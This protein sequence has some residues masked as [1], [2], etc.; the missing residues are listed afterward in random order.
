MP[1]RA[2]RD[3]A[4]ELVERSQASFFSQARERV[5][6]QSLAVPG[7]GAFVFAPVTRGQRRA[8]FFAQSFKFTQQPDRG[9]VP[10]LRAGKL[11]SLSQSDD[12]VTFGFHLPN[13]FHRFGKSRFGSLVFSLKPVQ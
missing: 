7:S 8:N 12:G 13:Q 3:L 5:F 4:V 10:V 11:E 1:G 9:F 2:L 6:P